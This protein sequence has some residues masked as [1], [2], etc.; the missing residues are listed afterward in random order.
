LP[1]GLVLSHYQYAFERREVSYFLLPPAAAGEVADPGDEALEEYYTRNTNNYRAPEYRALTVLKL[2][3]EELADQVEVPEEHIRQLYD[4]RHDF[5]QVPETREIEQLSFPS[6]EAAETALN[7]L[8]AGGDFENVG[9]T[10][11]DLGDVAQNEGIDEAVMEEAFALTEP[12]TTGVIDGALSYVIARVSS[13]TPGEATTYE[14]VRD[15]LRQELAEQT[16]SE[17]I[18]AISENVQDALAGGEDFADIGDRLNIP[19]IAVEAVD[20]NGMTPDGDE[21]TALTSTPGMIE[22]AFDLTEGEDTGFRDTPDGDFYVARLDAI[23]PAHVQSFDEVREAVLDDWRQDQ[24]AERLAAMADDA[25]SQ[26]N[27]GVSL[28]NVAASMGREVRETPRA[29]RR[30]DTS[31]IFSGSILEELFT[32]DPGHAIAG[33]VFLGSS[34]LVAQVTNVI[35]ADPDAEDAQVDTLQTALEDRVAAELINAYAD[36]AEAQVNVRVNEQALSQVVSN[37]N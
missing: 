24:I 15:E 22:A 25:A 7:L 13:I 9:G 11:V 35:P 8:N 31:E 30:G 26:I 1:G 36:N 4:I 33:P 28:A 34:Y 27:G 29:I 17:E 18:F 2:D 32:N 19:V 12:G 20:R 3:I 5:L 21:V 37:F 6:R 16:A 10:Y 23:A 14:E